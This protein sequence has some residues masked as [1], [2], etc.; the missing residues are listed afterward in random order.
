MNSHYVARR[1]CTR[2]GPRTYAGARDSEEGKNPII[3][4]FHA[5]EVNHEIEKQLTPGL[6][7]HILHMQ[8]LPKVARVR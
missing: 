6:I 3:N 5:S 1:L 2:I 7:A 4:Y 8:Q